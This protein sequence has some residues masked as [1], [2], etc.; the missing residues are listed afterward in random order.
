MDYSKVLSVVNEYENEIVKIRRDFHTYAEP[1]WREFRTSAKIAKMLD[2]NGIK[3]YM[4]PDA[5]N[6]EYVMGYPEDK[7][8]I[9]NEMKR[10]VE[11]GADEK[12][13]A[14]TKGYTGV[15]AVI[16]TGRE[17]PVTTLRFD[18]DSNDVDESLASDHAP[19]AGGYR[20]KNPQCMHACG[21]DGHA[22][23]G[24]VTAMTLNRIKDD[25]KGVIRICF[26]PAEE[27]VR[28]ALS[29]VKKGWFDDADY[30]LC[31]HLG[32][33]EN[34]GDIAVRGG[35]ML[36]TS[37][38]NAYIHG[39]PAHAGG[40]P[41][42]G[43]NALLAA[44][45]AALTSYSFT[46]DGRGAGRVNV[47]KLIAGTGRNVVPEYAEMHFETRGETTEI[48]EDIYK[49]VTRAIKAAAEMYGCTCEFKKMGGASGANSDLDFGNQLEDIIREALHIEPLKP[50]TG[51]G[52]SEDASYMMK[53][54]QEH[55]GKAVYM[56]LG[57]HTKGTAHNGEYDIDD[58]GLIC[59]ARVFAVCV[60]NLN[61]INK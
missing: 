12:Y 54:T 61:N 15:V 41:Q 57:T 29:M 27:G 33:A 16:D 21:H 26:Q 13:V 14:M 35:G 39:T 58:S 37:K 52:G 11:Q 5:V 49:K 48:E 32:G 25:L 24:L 1:A 34:I 44:A 56:R 28:G 20:S 31:G 51:L 53:A 17:G 55:G 45:T 42:K 50:T 30:F 22:S 60:S 19:T 38:F 59:A 43:N 46:Q 10:A 47:G 4:G 6:T 8:Y 23:I 36:A 18:I 7:E 9:E 40:S 2:E 3:F